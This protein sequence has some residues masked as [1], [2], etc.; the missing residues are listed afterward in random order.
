MAEK[1]TLKKE[2]IIT[3]TDGKYTVKCTNRETKS[4]AGGIERTFDITLDFS[5]VDIARV[6]EF[7]A[8]TVVI[9]EQNKLRKLGDSTLKAYEQS[10]TYIVNVANPASLSDEAIMASAKAFPKEKLR[11]LLADVKAQYGDL[12]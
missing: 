5:G 6:Y 7:A 4:D 8:A 1:V 10:N 2:Y 9:R 12:L 11:A 3:E